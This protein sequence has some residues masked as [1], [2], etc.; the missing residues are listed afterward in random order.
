MRSWKKRIA[1]MLLPVLGLSMLSAC[2]VGVRPGLVVEP[3]YYYDDAYVDVYG[4]YH[5]RAY[6]Y[7]HDGYWE[8]RAFVP[9]GYYSHVRV[10]RR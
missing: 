4:A 7:Y 3:G 10:Y 9:H 5:P 6:Y 2:Y 1:T 8:H